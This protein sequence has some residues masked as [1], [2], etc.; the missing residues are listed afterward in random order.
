MQADPRNLAIALAGLFQAVRLVQQTATGGTCDGMALTA[1]LTG[2]FNTSPDSAASVFG[3]LAGLV[4]GIDAALRQLEPAGAGRDLQLSR[5]AVT[6]LY[7]ERKLSR[8]PGMLA[9]IADGIERARGQAKEQGMTHPLVMARLAECYRQ[10]LST[11]RPRIIVS[12][13]QTV[14]VAADNQQRIRTLLLAAVRAAVLWRQ[15]GGGH[16][17]LLLRRRAL[18]R[19]L[20][21]LQDEARRPR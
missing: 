8:R 1:C 18:L 21:Q 12:G 13:E 5:Y 7:L 16:L 4:T 17:T 10:T 2:L 19:S 9:A 11:L 20:A 6:V 15:C 3:E 14:L